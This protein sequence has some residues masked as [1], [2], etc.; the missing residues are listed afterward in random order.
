MRIKI[1]NMSKEING[2]PVLQEIN[3]VF[4]SGNIYG[5]KGKNGSGRKMLMR[6]LCGLIRPTSGSIII[7]NKE[8]RKGSD[9]PISIGAQIEGPSFLPNYTG[10][11]NLKILA[12]IRSIINETMIKEAMRKVG[13]DPDD[14]RRYKNYTPE[15]QQ[16]L[17]AAC[18]LMEEPDLIIMEEPM[19]ALD[20]EGAS[21]VK[22]YL[23]NLKEKGSIII[24][25]CRD[26]D[27]LKSLSDE[28]YEMKEGRIAGVIHCES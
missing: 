20:E 22:D 16:K 14:K 5:L 15:M 1:E 8:L 9:K 11:V 7:H 2:T 3:A 23:M 18:V 10:F 25:A 26:K 4:H 12:S 24:V 21:L 27:E 19:S 13:L 6:C 17:G 28:I